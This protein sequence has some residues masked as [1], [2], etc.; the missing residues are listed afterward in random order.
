MQNEISERNVP[1]FIC[2]LTSKMRNFVSFFALVMKISKIRI[3]YLIVDC[4][5]TMFSIK[6]L[7][8]LG[9]AGFVMTVDRGNF[10]TCSQSGFCK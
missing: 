5:Y 4:S 2:V 1:R 9:L 7:W 6:W 8:V 10:K 3:S